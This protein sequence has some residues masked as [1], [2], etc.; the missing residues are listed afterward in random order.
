MDAP[1]EAARQLAV[2]LRNAVGDRSLRD[3]EAATGVSRMSIK[4]ALDGS[5]WLDTESLRK[6]EVHLGDL[7]PPLDRT[8]DP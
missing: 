1:A 7:W 3:I 6:L 8:P 4:A 5:A 2:N